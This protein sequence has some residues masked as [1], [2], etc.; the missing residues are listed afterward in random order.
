MSTIP[1]SGCQIEAFN[2]PN[3]LKITGKKTS[4]LTKEEC[5]SVVTKSKNT[6][7][8]GVHL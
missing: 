6:G 7:I 5:K 8:V 1:M 2:S 4:V 3:Y